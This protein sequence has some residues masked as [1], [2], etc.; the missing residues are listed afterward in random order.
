MSEGKF[1]SPAA[2]ASKRG[3]GGRSSFNGTVVTVFG[4][5]FLARSVVNKLAKIG[6]QVII[7]YRR[8]PYHVRDFKL[9]GDLGQILFLV[10]FAGLLR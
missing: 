9:A 8:D 5:G 10:S 6:S 7:P 4:P 3:T 1:P 2:Q